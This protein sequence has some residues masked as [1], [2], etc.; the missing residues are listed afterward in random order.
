MVALQGKELNIQS[1]EEPGK[2]IHEYRKDNHEHLTKYT[3]TPW[4]IYPD[5]VLRNYDSLDS[6]PLFLIASFKFWKISGDN[7]FLNLILPNIKLALD[8][9]LIYADTNGDGFFDYRIHPERTHGGLEVQNWMDSGESL[10][11][12]DGTPMQYPIAPVEVQAYSYAALKSWGNYFS[13][14]LPIYSNTLLERAHRL[15]ND[16]NSKFIYSE[17]KRINLASG[18]DGGNNIIKT[19]RSSAGHCLWAITDKN[20]TILEEKYIQP[21]VER[22]ARP[23][24]FEPSAGIRTLSSSSLKFEPNSYHNGSIWPHDSGIILQGLRNFKFDTLADQ[25][26]DAITL[27]ISH[28]QTPVELFAFDGNSYQEYR[29]PSGQ[30]ACKKQAWCAATLLIL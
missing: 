22:I 20:D 27:A 25:V 23:D 29:S 4:Y 6:T 17:D 7:S 28:F 18:I 8:W 19:I 24:L 9:M 30:T 2:C 14:S 13:T 15:K 26:S 12:E 16:F 1:G 21:V 10:F 11:H 5:G 3:V